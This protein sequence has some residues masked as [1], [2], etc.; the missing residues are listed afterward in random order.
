M[1]VRRLAIGLLGV[2]DVRREPEPVGVGDVHGRDHVRVG[3]EDVPVG[4]VVDED[5][6]GATGVAD[7]S[8]L[9]H[10]WD[11]PSQAHHDLSPGLLGVQRPHQAQL[12][13]QGSNTRTH[14]QYIA[15]C[16]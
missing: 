9:V 6:G 14:G 8:A 13:A 11:V 4:L 10:P 2:L 7:G 12:A 15:H 16:D 1:F 5:H 3:L